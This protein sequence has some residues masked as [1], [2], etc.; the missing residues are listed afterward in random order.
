[1]QTRTSPLPRF[2]PRVRQF[3]AALSAAIPDKPLSE[4]DFPALS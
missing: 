1:M 4:F 3:D 2:A